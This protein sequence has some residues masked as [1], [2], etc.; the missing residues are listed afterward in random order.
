[1]FM[2]VHESCDAGQSHLMCIIYNTFDVAAIV[3]M[4]P[5]IRFSGARSPLLWVDAI[6]QINI[7]ICIAREVNWYWLWEILDP[8]VWKVVDLLQWR[9]RADIWKVSRWYFVCVERASWC[10]ERLQIR[11]VQIYA[12]FLCNFMVR[13]RCGLVHVFDII[14]VGDSVV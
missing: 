3:A 2:S 12:L 5:Y 10:L 4:W 6:F 7:C 14:R 8:L 11:W 9:S 1:M 13:C